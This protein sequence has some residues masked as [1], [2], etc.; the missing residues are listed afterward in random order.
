M[1][2]TMD[3][4]QPKQAVDASEATNRRHT[5]TNRRRTTSS[6]TTGTDTDGG[7]GGSHKPGKWTRMGKLEESLSFTVKQMMTRF[8]YDSKVAP[9]FPRVCRKRPSSSQAGSNGGGDSGG[10]GG[11]GDSG[12][13]GGGGREALREAHAQVCTFLKTSIAEEFEEIAK[14]W[15]LEARLD[16]LD[17]LVTRA[18]KRD[19]RKMRQSRRR[20]TV[21]AA[22]A[23]ATTTAANNED[24][25]S[26]NVDK[27][28][29]EID[30]K[31]FA[32]PTP[33]Q[34]IAQRTIVLKQAEL[35]RLQTQLKALQESTQA[36]MDRL[37]VATREINEMHGSISTATEHLDQV[38]DSIRTALST[39]IT[40][41]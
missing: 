4:N 25:A 23:E 3:D 9:C 35:G 1:T 15:D 31:P 34:I 37:E 28:A 38:M 22:T 17:E 39:V 11:G 21:T 19:E 26:E 6:R 32:M 36:K 14:K 41:D 10:G 29:E 30:A 18:A 33:A 40:Y 16:Q 27:S 20:T 2:M 12:G 7:N 13:G 5:L 8:D 24:T